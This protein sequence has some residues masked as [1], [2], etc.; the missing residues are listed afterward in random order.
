M[1]MIIPPV[2]VLTAGKF[3]EITHYVYEMNSCMN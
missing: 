1:T 2:A 3:L